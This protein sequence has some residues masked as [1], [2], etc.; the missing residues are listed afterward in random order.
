VIAAAILI[1]AVVLGWFGWSLWWS[2]PLGY[3][4]F[5]ATFWG[6]RE[7]ALKHTRWAW[8]TAPLLGLILMYVGRWAHTIFSN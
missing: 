7:E 3:A 8:L 4:I 2:I 1:A 5:I 6:R